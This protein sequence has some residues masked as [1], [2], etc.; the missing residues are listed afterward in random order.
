MN[1]TCKHIAEVTPENM[2]HKADF[3][4]FE[5]EEC[6]KSHSQWIQLRICQ[7]CGK[8][9]CCESS[10]NQH[11]KKHFEETNH[12]VISS[13]ELGSNWLYCYIDDITTNY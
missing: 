5:C 1:N 10:P 2:F 7:T 11:M 13:A 9:L 3:V 6:V 8:M 4:K 12:P